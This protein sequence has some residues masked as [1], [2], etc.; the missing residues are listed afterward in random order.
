MLPFEKG[1]IC[2]VQYLALKVVKC[3]AKRLKIGLQ[4]KIFLPKINFE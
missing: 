3:A 2:S 1:K 4:I